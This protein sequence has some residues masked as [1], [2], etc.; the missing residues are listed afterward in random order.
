[1]ARSVGTL[2]GLF[3]TLALR[4]YARDLATA[5]PTSPEAQERIATCHRRRPARI[6]KGAFPASPPAAPSSDVNSP[7]AGVTATR[8]VRIYTVAPRPSGARFITGSVAAEATIDE[9]GCVEALRVLESSSARLEQAALDAWRQWV[10]LPATAEGKPVKSTY[11]LVIDFKREHAAPQAAEGT[12]FHG[13]RG[14]P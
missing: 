3:V 2:V 13:L 8:P 11:S 9:D 14:R 6:E 10:F 5:D 12:P 1:M 4:A 7:T